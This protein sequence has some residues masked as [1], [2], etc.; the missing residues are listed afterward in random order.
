MSDRQFYNEYA[1][2]SGIVLYTYSPFMHVNEIFN[3]VETDT[4]ASV[5]CSFAVVSL[6]ETF[7][8]VT[9]VGIAYSCT[10]IGQFYFQ[11][12]TGTCSV[13]CA[14]NAQCNVNTS[15]VRCKL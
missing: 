10:C 8:D 5:R 14:N 15:S 11:H 13:I 3:E 6:I 1:S 9:L 7:E 12:F 2:A 4:A